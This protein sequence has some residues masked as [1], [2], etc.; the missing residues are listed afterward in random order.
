MALVQGPGVIGLVWWA[1][2]LPE[3]LSGLWAHQDEEEPN[4]DLPDKE[5]LC[6]ARLWGEPISDHADK[7]PPCMGARPFLPSVVLKNLVWGASADPELALPL[8]LA[9]MN[10]RLIVA[11]RLPLRQQ[12]LAVRLPL[13]QQQVAERLPL[14]LP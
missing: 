6:M 5:A 14:L 9:L 2:G 12:L 10:W 4:S 11:E 13:L 8:A 3:V 1:R 7:E